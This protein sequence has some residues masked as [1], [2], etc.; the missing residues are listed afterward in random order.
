MKSKLLRRSSIPQERV[1]SLTKAFEQHHNHIRPQDARGQNRP[2]RN[3][4]SSHALLQWAE[5]RNAP[6]LEQL[7]DPSSVTFSSPYDYSFIWPTEFVAPIPARPPIIFVDRETGYYD[8]SIET[9][10]AL[11]SDPAKSATFAGSAIGVGLTPSVS[12]T[13]TLAASVASL[14]SWFSSP[15]L[16]N[17]SG[18][19]EGLA[20]YWID[21]WTKD[22][23]RFSRIDVN[24]LTLWR[25]WPSSSGDAGVFLVLPPDHPRVGDYA[26]L[27]T[28][29][30]I[31][32]DPQ[33][34]Y[35]CWV[36]FSAR[37]QANAGTRPA[38]GYASLWGLLIDLT[39]SIS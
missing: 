22:G 7:K 37:I 25:R 24:S 32:V 33:F 27:P 1:I 16:R 2:N 35:V 9:N 30:G 29:A 21:E 10:T 4:L 26:A 12:G 8:F 19:T 34:D 5:R 18:V 17:G 31:P 6:H 38:R 11:S 15:G 23:S 20:G 14:S 3:D 28:L 39:A 36:W 13:M